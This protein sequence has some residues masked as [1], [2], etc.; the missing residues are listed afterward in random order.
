[1]FWEANINGPGNTVPTNVCPRELNTRL[2]TA[3]RGQVRCEGHCLERCPPSSIRRLPEIKLCRNAPHALHIAT[4]TGE[5]P[6]QAT[7]E[8]PVC[9]PAIAPFA[10]RSRHRSTNRMQRSTADSHGETSNF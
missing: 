10:N 5:R 9:G 6:S 7:D 3:N 2:G 1:M 8:A 4:E